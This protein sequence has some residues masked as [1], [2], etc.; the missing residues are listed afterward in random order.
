MLGTRPFV[1]ISAN[2]LNGIKNSWFAC[3]AAISELALSTSRN[4]SPRV[5]RTCLS[6]LPAY[7][8]M[9]F[10]CSALYYDMQEAKRQRRRNLVRSGETLLPKLTSGI[11]SPEPPCY[12][13]RNS[14]TFGD[15]A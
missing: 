9:A 2:R 4:V 5:S 3:R 8:L 15:P 12:A 6:L 14:L 7:R 11:G 10:G 13:K 1:S